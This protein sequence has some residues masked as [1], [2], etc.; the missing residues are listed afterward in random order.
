MEALA[1]QLDVD[2]ADNP[3]LPLRRV[4]EL[5]LPT[6]P[7]DDDVLGV[8]ASV[9]DHL[10]ADVSFE[11]RLEQLD[12]VDHVLSQRRAELRAC[13]HDNYHGLRS[14][15]AGQEEGEQPTRRAQPAQLP[16]VSASFE[17][18]LMRRPDGDGD[19]TD[20]GSSSGWV[21]LGSAGTGTESSEYELEYE[22]EDRTIEQVRRHQLQMEAQERAA[23]ALQ[24]ALQQQQDLAGEEAA[25]GVGIAHAQGDGNDDDDDDDDDYAELL[26]DGEL[27]EQEQQW[28]EQQLAQN[29][30]MQQQWRQEQRAATRYSQGTQPEIRNSHANGATVPT[31]TG[32]AAADAAADQQAL[33]MLHQLQVEKERLKAELDEQL[34][35]AEM[36]EQ[37]NQREGEAAD[38]Q[39]AAAAAAAATAVTSQQPQARGGAS[40]EE[41]E[42]EIKALEMLRQLH[43]E[44]QR[45]QMELQK[46]LQMAATLD[47]QVQ[48][49]VPHE[50]TEQ[51]QEEDELGGGYGNASRQRLDDD[52]TADEFAQAQKTLQALSAEKD[53][54]E[55][56]L[57]TVLA[58][59]G[60]T[61]ADDPT[62]QPAST[63][64]T[65]P[66]P[67]SG[68]E[69]DD[70]YMEARATLQALAAE[71]D[72]LQQQLQD[73]LAM[74]AEM[75]TAASDVDQNAASS[76]AADPDKRISAAAGAGASQPSGSNG[77]DNDDL[78]VL[79]QLMGAD[80]AQLAAMLDGADQ[81]T[82]MTMMSQLVSQREQL[83][84]EEKK[85]E[86]A[87]QTEMEKL[88][89]LKAL[90]QEQH[91]RLRAE[92]DAAAQATAEGRAWIEEQRRQA[93]E[94]GRE[95]LGG[96]V[97]VDV[98]ADVDAV[99]DGGEQ[100]EDDEDGSD[101]GEVDPAEALQ[102]LE[103]LKQQLAGLARDPATLT[104]EDIERERALEQEL[105]E[106]RAVLQ[107]QVAAA[108]REDEPE[109][110]D[111]GSARAVTER[112][113]RQAWAAEAE[114]EAVAEDLEE[115]EE[116]EEDVPADVAEMLE[117]LRRQKLELEAELAQQLELEA[118][119]R[120]ELNR[121]RSLHAGLVSRQHQQ[122]GGGLQESAELLQREMAMPP[123]AT[124]LDMLTATKQLQELRQ[125][126]E[127]TGVVQGEQQ[128]RRRQQDEGEEDV[129]ML[130][131]L[132]R[133]REALERQLAEKQRQQ[134]EAEEMEQQVTQLLQHKMD[135][136]RR[137]TSQLQQVE[138]GGRAAASTATALPEPESDSDEQAKAQALQMLAELM[139]EKEQ[140]GAQLE[141]RLAE[142][143]FQQQRLDQ[144]I[145]EEEESEEEDEEEL[146][147]EEGPSQDEEEKQQRA[148]MA[149]LASL[150]EEKD[151]LNELLAEEQ[152]LQAELQDKEA[153]MHQAIAASQ[154]QQAANQSV[155][156]GTSDDEDEEA[157]QDAGDQRELG[158]IAFR[159]TLEGDVNTL[160]SLT[161][162]IDVSDL[163]AEP[164][165]KALVH[166]AAFRGHCDCLSLL[167][168]AGC[169]LRMA[170]TEGLT[171][172]H[173]A[174]FEDH[175]AVL[176]QLMVAGVDLLSPEMSD[177]QGRTPL[178]LAET[179]QADACT[180]FLKAVAEASLP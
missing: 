43:M 116:E 109:D 47:Q 41:E 35:M 19:A 57:E 61:G 16:P 128:Q 29:Q 147:E 56:Q 3:P 126:A 21:D 115:Q 63:D 5:G 176:Q 1:A 162:M 14:T 108:E 39:T 97:D 11:A 170:T 45:L 74:A 125:Q 96:D 60:A 152:R 130:Q 40:Q 114:G 10:D 178:D 49:K 75:D 13:I 12:Y 55:Q 179:L 133:E 26:D 99:D 118:A 7:V 64:Q 79:E 139:R 165:G 22:N 131:A 121:A 54:L 150:A 168:Q 103:G 66:R 48:A 123:S 44:K 146:E 76:V 167:S 120:A 71:K 180:R 92:H 88:M 81:N 37:T 173:F 36:L 83:E 156:V 143:Q 127:E 98:D 101:L 89:M 20:G 142:Q 171:P 27:L 106:L 67:S 110:Q 77:G 94:E 124:E 84:T 65:S 163:R 148:M 82:L 58:M 50:V 100:A 70:E 153:A 154:E 18:L 59:A 102:I 158:Q 161:T 107:A 105:L 6:G 34:A 141:A 8:F 136:K 113:R 149:A 15:L 129:R 32:D 9:V 111:Q 169:D 166:I 91:D 157:G 17:D 80:E 38:A 95:E 68:V 135:E 177:V 24:Q 172:A 4:H 145:Q 122:Q 175:V 144:T 78:S 90:Q 140:L 151:K 104:Q 69:A 73:V 86:D 132:L 155:T 164:D 119:E 31:Q 62:T 117:A 42:A 134:Q 138:Q 30:A 53:R 112:Q 52:D 46:Q 87:L 160:G 85:R 33:Q 93:R 25:V 137:L 159:A 174:V 51:R 72:R 28:L 23:A 2:D